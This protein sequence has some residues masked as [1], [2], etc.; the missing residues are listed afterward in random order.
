MS[1]TNKQ[2]RFVEEYLV[3]LNATQ[4]AIRSG[5]SEKT[6]GAIGTENLAKPLI[7]KAIEEA[8]QA[9]SERT[10]I[11][12]DRVLNELAK[13]GFSNMMDFMRVGADGD[14]VTDFSALSRDKAA[15]ISEVTVETFKDGT[16]K[17]ARDV[18]RVKFKLT[19]KRAALVDIG[20]HLG[21]FKERFEHSGPEGGPI[22]TA[23][24]STPG[25]ARALAAF[26]ART[27]AEK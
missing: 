14:P 1:L 23:D 16:S 15:A 12:A 24:T 4:A 19:D 7:A 5:Y 26:L 20:R 9:R 2:A 6:A 13:L 18:R 27:R 8:Q 22:Q 25:R 11:T 3:D 10:E 21:M 17:D